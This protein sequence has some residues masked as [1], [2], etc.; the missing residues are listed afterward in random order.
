[1]LQVAPQFGVVHGSLVLLPGGLFLLLPLGQHP[2][3]LRA[4][5]KTPEAIVLHEPHTGAILSSRIMHVQLHHFS[6]SLNKRLWWVQQ[7]G[8]NHMTQCSS[9][10]AITYCSEEKWLILFQSVL[11]LQLN[12]SDVIFFIKL[13]LLGFRQIEPFISIVSEPLKLGLQQLTVHSTKSIMKLH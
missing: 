6:F 8:I 4:V 13:K 9:S 3:D 5:K 10:Y 1:M 12:K 7:Q 11:L 2:S